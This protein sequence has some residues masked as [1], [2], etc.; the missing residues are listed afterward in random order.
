VHP[1]GQSQ[2]PPK[3]ARTVATLTLRS[4]A[5]QRA[6]IWLGLPTPPEPSPAPRSDRVTELLTAPRG[7]APAA[8]CDPPRPLAIGIRAT[9]VQ[10][11]AADYPSYIVA[12]ALRR[13]VHT[14]GLPA[15]ARRRRRSGRARRAQCGAVTEGEAEHAREQLRQLARLSARGKQ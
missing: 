6:A 1:R 3:V 2:P 14:L 15:R 8:F 12:K 11:M 9:T 7:L 4:N 10:R 5:P 13:M